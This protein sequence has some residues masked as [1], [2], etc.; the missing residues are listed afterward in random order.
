MISSRDHLGNRSYTR[1]GMYIPLKF[2]ILEEVEKADLV[3]T[4]D[5]K[6]TYV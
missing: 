3:L 6:F 4:N 5:N 2:Q 1:S